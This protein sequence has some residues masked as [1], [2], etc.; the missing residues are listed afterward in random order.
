VVI[1]EQS[2]DFG[3]PFRYAGYEYDE[4]GLYYLKAR[5]YDPTIARFMQENT[6]RGQLDFALSLNRY[7]Y[8]YNEPLM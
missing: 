1:T 8:C 6:Y 7:T 3:N 2:G 4:S 5:H